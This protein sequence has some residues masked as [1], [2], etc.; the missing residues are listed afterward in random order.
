MKTKANNTPNAMFQSLTIFVTDQTEDSFV[1]NNDSS[2]NN[3]TFIAN[4][5]PT[6]ITFKNSVSSL[7]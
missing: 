5:I 3:T 1:D 6:T 2:N 4:A 7:V